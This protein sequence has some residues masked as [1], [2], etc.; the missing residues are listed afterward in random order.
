MIRCPRCNTEV[1]VEYLDIYISEE[2]CDDC[3]DEL[4][5]INITNDSHYSNL[6]FLEKLLIGD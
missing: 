2:V 3:G 1:D 6:T 4:L 5:E